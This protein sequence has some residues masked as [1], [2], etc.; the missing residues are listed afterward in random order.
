MFTLGRESADPVGP[1]GGWPLTV[2]AGPT[3]PGQVALELPLAQ[4]DLPPG[5][6]HIDA[7]ATEEGLPF[8]QDRI[9]V[10]V[11]PA[12]TAPVG[13]VARGNP[14]V[15]ACAH[16]APDVEVFLN[17]QRVA[18]AQVTFVSAT[19]VDFTVPPATAT[20]PGTI[21]LRA[22]KVAGPDEPVTIT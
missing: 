6:R 22:G 17:G 8:G 21:M 10:T 5:E 11:V 1:P 19:Q 3:P 14:V 15:L 2:G 18:P 20:G 7:T 12:L 4:A 13:A 9:G 16:A